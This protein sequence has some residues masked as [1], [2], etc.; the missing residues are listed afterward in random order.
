M[1][2]SPEASI[3]ARRSTAAWAENGGNRPNISAQ[4]ENQHLFVFFRGAFFIFPILQC[5]GQTGSGSG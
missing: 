3:E 2:A 5:A 4:I 1:A